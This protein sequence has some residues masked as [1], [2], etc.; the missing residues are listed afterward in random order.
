MVFFS[1]KKRRT[2]KVTNAV[3]NLWEVGKIDSI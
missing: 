3:P 2:K 1:G